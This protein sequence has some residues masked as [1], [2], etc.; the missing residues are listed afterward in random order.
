M[1]VTVAFALPGLQEVLEVEVPDGA[2]VAQALGAA[3]LAERFPG[4]DFSALDAGLWGVRTARDTA[5][6]EGDRV[7]LYRPLEADP[8]EMRRRRVKAKPS[9]RSRSGP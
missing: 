6:R 1:R 2:T 3:P 8:R 9:P 4:I 7:E 5:L